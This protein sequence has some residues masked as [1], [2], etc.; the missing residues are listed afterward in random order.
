[1]DIIDQIKGIT[2]PKVLTDIINIARG[3]KSEFGGR[4]KKEDPAKKLAEELQEFTN[5]I[6]SAKDAYVSKGLT[7]E[8]K[9]NKY[10]LV[11][12][13]VLKRNQNA[14]AVRT[15]TVDEFNSILGRL[16]DTNIKSSDIQNAL[17]GSGIGARKLQPT[18]GNIL[19]GMNGP[20][21]IEKVPGTDKAGTRYRK[22]K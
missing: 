5:N 21:P 12:K 9:T 14:S 13:W 15:M 20:S 3:N 10:G 16:S 6:V 1:M 7:V 22:V 18:L 8:I 11:T 17:I 2:D 4:I 19:R